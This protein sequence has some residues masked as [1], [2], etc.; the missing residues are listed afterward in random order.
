MTKQNLLYT[1]GLVLIFIK[2]GDCFLLLRHPKHHQ[3]LTCVRDLNPRSTLKLTK[4]S[5]HVADNL[6]KKIFQTMT[7]SL[8][9]MS[10]V[11]MMTGSMTPI[12]IQP[13]EASESRLI[14]EIPGS[15]LVFKDTLNV[16]SFDDPKVKVCVLC[17]K[18]Y[19]SKHLPECIF[20]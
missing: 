15:G 19:A 12:A 5:E 1:A 3:I 11:V 9:I 14:G 6:A 18:T 10:N 13:A 4:I 17:D 2:F 20:R 7:S 16:E 8:F